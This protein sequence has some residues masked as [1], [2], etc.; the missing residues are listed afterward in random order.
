[1]P[2]NQIL[3]DGQFSNQFKSKSPIKN[4]RQQRQ[5][6][7]SRSGNI[8]LDKD[9]PVW[10]TS[11]VKK[12]LMKLGEISQE[13]RKVLQGQLLLKCSTSQK[14]IDA[15]QKAQK[16]NSI[17]NTPFTKTF[18]MSQL[19]KSGS[20]KVLHERKI[21]ENCTNSISSHLKNPSRQNSRSHQKPNSSKS[22]EKRISETTSKPSKDF[23]RESH[24]P[25]NR[26]GKFKTNQ[27]NRKL[28][29]EGCQENS[30]LTKSIRSASSINKL[31]ELEDNLRKF[32]SE[33]KN[34]VTETC[35]PRKQ[36]GG[37]NLQVEAL[38]DRDQA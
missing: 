35:N 38:I 21:L 16:E 28:K 36:S 1:M 18:R 34:A 26:N 12:S 37:V 22:I 5:V 14:S 10:E 27:P 11:E 29:Q 32:I 20:S 23:V 2:Q 8:I 13:K 24:S 19:Q 25:H 33:V 7:G 4:Q 9:P 15:I 30:K 31:F 17:K 6:L 3:Q